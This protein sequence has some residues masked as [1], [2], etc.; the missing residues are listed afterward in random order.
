MHESAPQPGNEAP[1]Q[2]P[3]GTRR[4][5]AARW[6]KRV[7]AL[8][9]AVIVSVFLL[10]FSID[11]G[12]FPKLKQ[13]A[14]EQAQSFLERPMHI[15]RI[16]ALLSPGEFE[17][18]DVVIDG[19]SPGDRP[20]LHADRIH[21]FVPWWEIPLTHDIRFEVRM[22]HWQMLIE[23]WA[24]HTNL[25]K[26]K[27]KNPPKGP[28]RFTKTATLVYANDGQ[29]TYED[30]TTP[31]S[32]VAPNLSFALVRATNL[33]QY[34][35]EARFNGGVVDI[36]KFVP[37]H[38]DMSTRFV[39]D[40]SLVKLTHIDLLTD[41]AKTHVTGSVDFGHWPEQTY[42]VNSDLDF[43][44]M[45]RLFFSSETWRV[46]GQGHFN[47][48][49][50]LY[51]GGRNL[52][53]DFTSEH[54]VVDDLAFDDL[55]GS[56][57]W[58]PDQFRVTHVDSAFYGGN[59][60]MS[61]G[62]APL[63]TPAGAD[64][65]LHADYDGIDV[66]VLARVFD[67]KGFDPDG[68]ATGNLTM[69][70]PSGQLHQKLSGG[71]ETIVTAAGGR[72]AGALLPRPL[73][74][75]PPDPGAFEPRRAL[76]PLPVAGE[77]VYHFDNGVMTFDPSW[78]ATRTT[79][80][81]FSGT[82]QYG[83]DTHLPFHVTSL[84]WQDSDRLLAAIRTARGTPS[85]AVPLGGAGVFDG[86]MTG[87]F[88]SPR[89][90][91]HFAGEDT[92]AFDVT[93]GQAAG[94]I[95]MEN[96][97]VT[98]KGGVI[99]GS[100]SEMIHADGRFAL[101][102]G[103]ADHGEEINARIRVQNWPMEDLRHA[104]GLDDWPVDAMATDVNV[105]VH[106][107]YARMEGAGTMTLDHGVAWREEFQH[108]TGD[109]TFT[110]DGLGIS[111]IA[112]TKG[113]GTI[114]GSADIKWADAS[115]S[116][117][118]E[119]TGVPVESLDNFQ[120]PQAPLTGLMHF[121]AGGAA[122]FASPQYAFTVDVPDLYVGGE[123]I[124]V[125][126]GHATVANNVL[127]IDRLDTSS[128][129]L[130]GTASGR[131][132]LDDQYDAEL[133]MGI[134]N[135]SI[136]PY[137]RLLAPQMSGVNRIE[138]TGS[139]RISGPLADYAHLLVDTTISSGTVTLFDYTLKNDGPVHFTLE[140]AAMKIGRFRL[141]GEGTSLTA[142]GSAS[143]ADRTVDLHADGDASLAILRGFPDLITGGQA[144][145]RADV[146]GSFDA[147]E[148]S[149]QMDITD[150][151]LR[152]RPLPHSFQ[153]IS[154]PVR[155]DRAGINVDGL[156][157]TMGDGDV[158]FGGGITLDGFHLASYNLTANGRT[159][160]LRY[161]EGF[162]ST[163]DANLALTGAAKTP[164]LSG[165]VDVI[166]SNYTRQ[167]DADLL[168][169]AAAGGALP[170]TVTASG[171]PTTA[172]SY[173]LRYDIHLS[174]LPGSLHINNDV[175]KIEGNADLWV[176]GTIDK[177]Q[178]SG[179]VDIDHGTVQFNANRYSV[180]RGTIS[181]PDPTKFEP[182]FDIEAVT[183][184]N[185]GGETFE[186]TVE[187]NGTSAKPNV[188]FSSDPYLSPYDT[189][190]LLMGQT[191]DVGTVEQRRLQA[192]E[193]GQQRLMQTA[194]AQLLFSPITSRV[195]SVF[196]KALPIDTVQ[197]TP[198]LQ[199]EASLTQLTPTARVTL[200]Q[201]ISSR[202]FLTYSRELS[203]AQREV[204]LLEYEQSDRIT[205]VLSRNEDRNYALDFRIRHVF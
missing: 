39:L 79:Y 33:E 186:V 99:H 101:G 57:E 8:G 191:P 83:G 201:R 204:I 144:T 119:G 62:V 168:G 126:S 114:S 137:L 80:V 175:A 56:L 124:G 5:A 195:G 173:P 106:G 20:F 104:F 184:P 183:R 102:T 72:V 1:S 158:T 85:N 170:A 2:R 153:H 42:V 54:A 38:T 133:T 60:R 87:T 4:R 31:W 197:I 193:I 53:G 165:T 98:V 145:L 81:A 127:T 58:L 181:F 121:T 24:D 91:G 156:R 130:Q 47:G 118:A 164:T 163:V 27:P 51:E 167:L 115:Y 199:N 96:G 166:Y 93:W 152:Y 155:F 61:Y 71:G 63:G 147:P 200:G 111:N 44:T 45:K 159:M 11:L 157:A 14:E 171:T 177:P 205:W 132:A 74:I 142:S 185:A 169:L 182:Y 36:Q 194:A 161:P 50:H 143:L 26:L 76:G 92:R 151:T 140:D 125:F 178:L 187:L 25:P 69:A 94:D 65:S 52:S 138:V 189:I 172:S 23:K 16:S 41:G 95:V 123:G 110:G 129:R 10:T 116:F 34:V 35:G 109:L 86:T 6:I 7:L 136:D 73:P 90:E 107:P 179:Q 150:G 43:A 12:R 68:R 122:P 198:L 192:P 82:T 146:S 40:G 149:G 21:V 196:E 174:A 135:S 22:D 160:R 131:I 100:A 120:L 28:S 32:V 148:F 17:L 70:W 37:M 141:V 49:F 46:A 55:H 13:I 202:A 108:A 89:I 9:V 188:Q 176:R 117:N 29:F 66:R 88:G 67:L 15:G 59:L 30:H 78:A 97:Y 84:D 19:R 48:I 75:V 128:P 18:D 3:R 113:P 190:L 112:M 139:A 154:G 180:T 203:G 134:V 64:Q 103:P 162:V 77:I 105:T